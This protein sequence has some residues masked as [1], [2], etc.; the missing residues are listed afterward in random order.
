MPRDFRP[1]SASPISRI[2]LTRQHPPKPRLHE[3]VEGI[4]TQAP[5]GLRTRAMGRYEVRRLR[6]MRVVVGVLYWFL[7]RFLTLNVLYMSA[8]ENHR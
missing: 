2:L 1:R 6:E 4:F 5:G 7:V 3:R 8:G